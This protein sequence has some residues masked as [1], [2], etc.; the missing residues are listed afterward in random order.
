MEP[1]LIMLVVVGGVALLLATAQAMSR[2]PR[3]EV[4]VAPTPETADPADP[5]PP[6]T[7]EA[8]RTVG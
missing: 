5:T 1:L 4:H 8:K 7:E 6:T 2:R 3:D